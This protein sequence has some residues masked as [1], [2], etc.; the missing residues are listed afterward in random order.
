MDKTEFDKL[1]ILEK[2]NLLKV[3]AEYIGARTHGG[4]FVHLFEL[5]GYFVEAY[6]P[7]GDTRYLWIEI[8]NNNSSLDSY[9]SNINIKY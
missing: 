4:Y 9:L 8:V 3:S 7:I 2:Y 1:D 5:H 6:M